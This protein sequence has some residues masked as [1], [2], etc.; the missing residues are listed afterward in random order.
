MQGFLRWPAWG[1]FALLA[2]F[3]VSN[4]AH[5]WVLLPAPGNIGFVLAFTAFS[6]LHAGL[7]LG[8]RR[9][10]LFFGLTVLISFIMEEVGVRTGWVFGRYH[11][12]DMLGTKLGHVPV[13]IPLG[14]FMMIYPSWVVAQALL[15]G[16]DTRRPMGAICL[17]LAA[18]F[19]MTGWDMVM[20]PPMVAAGNWIW[21]DGGPYFGV[22][23]HNYF[24]WMLNT[25][26]VYLA[27]DAFRGSA[28][29]RE[30]P[31]YRFGGAFAALPVVIYV[32]FA[33]EYLTPNRQP[34]LVIISVF[35]MLL[36]SLLALMRLIL[37]SANGRSDLG[38]SR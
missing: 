21:E 12:S 3:I 35:S 17:A 30:A 9:L 18:A 14:W 33:L 26:L 7:M 4:I 13:L 6:L 23:L 38:F 16:V 29:R 32:L 19:A 20:D 24:G 28:T 37:P 8:G 11:Y 2:Y 36:P 10:V 31:V 34:S 25:F 22:P 1:L 15:R 27:F 5:H